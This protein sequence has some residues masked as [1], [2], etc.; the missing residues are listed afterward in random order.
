M[1]LLPFA[2]P[3]LIDTPNRRIA[4][5][6]R[7]LKSLYGAISSTVNAN[8]YREHL[9]TVEV[10]NLI[11]LEI[12]DNNGNPLWDRYDFL[13]VVLTHFR[14][15]NDGSRLKFQYG[16]GGS[17]WTAA[18]YDWT[19]GTEAASGDTSIP[20]CPVVL[21]QGYDLNEILHGEMKLELASGEAEQGPRR[22][23][24]DFQWGDTLTQP[25]FRAFNGQYPTT[26]H[27][28]AFRFFYDVGN[29]WTGK[30][31]L[32]GIPIR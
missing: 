10:S 9:Q 13:F 22:C 31:I 17:W 16:G 30:A 1:K 15:I 6:Y 14:P 12:G 21:N 18:N 19:T 3:A 7:S 2:F 23:R 4:N 8:E 27:V 20:I 32:Y 24:G 25:R 28:T 11:T 5:V 29:I 26:G